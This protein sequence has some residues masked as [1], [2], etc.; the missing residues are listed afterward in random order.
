MPETSR[1]FTHLHVHTEYSLLDGACRIDR[2]MERVKALGQT[3]IAITDHG[4]MYGL[5]LI[6]IFHSEHAV[7]L[8]IGTERR[9][10]CARF[11][12]RLY[13]P[14]AHQPQPCPETCLLYTSCKD[15]DKEV[16]IDLDKRGLLF[17]APVFEHSYPH[18]W[19]CD[20]PLI[21]Y[22]R[23]SWFIKM[24]AVKDDLIRNNNTVNWIP[25][26]IGK[27]RFGDWLE[28]MCIRDR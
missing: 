11:T 9:G 25:E 26:S 7:P 10:E 18:C 6:H 24:T 17:S 21:Y 14:S 27:G 19:R 22:A 13:R 15:A 8:R 23:D 2:L 4:A 3:A 1:Q 28:K 5:S 16:L 12:R 20:T